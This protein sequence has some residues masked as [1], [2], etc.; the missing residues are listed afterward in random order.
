MESNS[1]NEKTLTEKIL[2]QTEVEANGPIAYGKYSLTI[3]DD[4]RIY[5]TPKDQTQKSTVNGIANFPF[6]IH[7]KFPINKLQLDGQ[8]TPPSILF[9]ILSKDNIAEI[10]IADEKEVKPK[11]SFWE[12]VK[13]NYLKESKY[14]FFLNGKKSLLIRLKKFKIGP[15]PFVILKA[16]VTP[17]EL[18]ISMNDFDN[19]CK[20]FKEFGYPIKN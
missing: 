11:T 9:I 12:L 6:G 19:A 15:L 18:L 7:S 17:A 13:P 20:K 5:I 10:S 3:L 2:F 14:A 16:N 1:T 8:W 4:Q